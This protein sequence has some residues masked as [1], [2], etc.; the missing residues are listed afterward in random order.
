MN[1]STTATIPATYVGSLPEHH[2]PINV[3][4]DANASR[5]NGDLRFFGWTE[6]GELLTG[7][8]VTS[9]SFTA[10]RPAPVV[11][12]VNAREVLPAI[13]VDRQ[14]RQALLANVPARVYCERHDIYDCPFDGI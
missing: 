12:R 6:A 5:I 13:P 1:K 7:I 2:G 14:D 4:L 10:P 11:Y 8:R 3:G 9:L